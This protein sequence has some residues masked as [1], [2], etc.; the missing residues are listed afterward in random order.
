MGGLTAISSLARVIGPIF[1]TDLYRMFG[2][3]VISGTALGL[4]LAVIL[5]MLLTYKRLVP[6]GK[7]QA[8]VDKS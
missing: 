6:A 1:I 3:Y 4:M 8:C 2:T 5:V 7:V